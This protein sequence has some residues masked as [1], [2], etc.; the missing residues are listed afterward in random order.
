MI[1]GGADFTA[2]GA[3]AEVGGGMSV[4]V[5]DLL[6]AGFMGGTFMDDIMTTGAG[7]AAAGTVLTTTEALDLAGSVNTQRERKDTQQ[8]IGFEAF[9]RLKCILYNL[10]STDN[11]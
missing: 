9:Y 5:V 2:D 10:L 1:S 7:G 8:K 11:Q 6:G 4:T 3:G